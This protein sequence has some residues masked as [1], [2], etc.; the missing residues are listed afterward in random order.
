MMRPNVRVQEPQKGSPPFVNGEN[1]RKSPLPSNETLQGAP[2]LRSC[3]LFHCL[4][5][6]NHPDSSTLTTASKQDWM[7]TFSS[8]TNEFLVLLSSPHLLHPS[9]PFQ[10]HRA[11]LGLCRH[12]C[13]T[14]IAIK[15]LHSNRAE[16][17]PDIR[18]DQ[19]SQ[20]PQS[21]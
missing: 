12:T 3:C 18:A 8:L 11:H 17:L 7:H 20:K 4:N 15:R 2:G 5:S 6:Y 9:T 1:V 19:C 14:A 16:T 13:H 10:L 21:S